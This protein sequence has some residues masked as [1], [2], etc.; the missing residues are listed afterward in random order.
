[1]NSKITLWRTLL[2]AILLFGYSNYSK[3][4]YD[5]IRS[6]AKSSLDTI[7][8][9]ATSIP[10]V[11]ENG[12]WTAKNSV[13]DKVIS[14]FVTTI[15]T[16]VT[17][18]QSPA[19]FYWTVT[20]INSNIIS[21]DSFI[22][23]D[24]SVELETITDEDLCALDTATLDLSGLYLGVPTY[25]MW[26]ASNLISDPFQAD[27]G[28]FVT[29]YDT[30][31]ASVTIGNMYCSDTK[32]FK[33]TT[34]KNQYFSSAIVPAT[35]YG[36]YD[37]HILTSAL[38]SMLYYYVWSTGD[39]IV[40]LH[41][42]DPGAYTLT[43]YAKNPQSSCTYVYDFYVYMNDSTAANNCK[44]YP[45][46]NG[47]K[48]YNNERIINFENLTSGTDTLGK[49]SYWEFG[50]GEFSYETSPSHTYS[51]NGV[52]MVT[53]T[54]FSNTCSQNFVNYI[55]VGTINCFADFTIKKSLTNPK[56]FTITNQSQGNIDSYSWDFGDGTLSFEANPGTHTF[57]ENGVYYMTLTVRNDSTNCVYTGYEYVHVGDSVCFADFELF[58]DQQTDSVTFSNNSLNFGSGT[59]WY[60]TMGDTYYGYSES[61]IHKYAEDGVY[62]VCLSGYDYS[63]D[64][65]HESCKDVTVGKNVI[66]A[67]YTYLVDATTKSITLNES[68][69]GTAN[70]LFW[71]FGDGEYSEAPNVT[72]TYTKNGVYEV[73]LF[74]YNSYG[75]YDEICQEIAV[76]ESC[77]SKFAPVILDATAKEVKCTDES[78]DAAHW[79]W[80]FGDGSIDTTQNPKYKYWLP[81]EYLV[82]LS[83]ANK[84]F[85][86]FDY[87]S[88][89]VAVGA[90]DA[91]NAK[92]EYKVKADSNKVTF[93]NKSTGSVAYYYWDFGNGDFS[94]EKEPIYIYDSPGGYWVTLV[95]S[96]ASGLAFDVK[97]D[98]VQVGK[99]PCSAKFETFINEKTK[100]VSFTNQAKGNSDFSYWEFG[101][102]G[103]SF[104]SEPAHKYPYD[105][106]F[107][108]A[109]VTYHTAT[110]CMDYY[111]TD[112]QIGKI[113]GLSSNFK[114]QVKAEEMKVIFNSEV[115]GRPKYYVWNFDDNTDLS[116]EK[117]PTHTYTK[118]GYYDVCL[119]ISDSLGTYYD[120]ECKEVQVLPT[121]KKADFVQA[122]FVY[123]TDSINKKVTFTDKSVGDG[124]KYLWVFG[125]GT[126]SSDKNP[127]KTY[128]KADYYFVTLTVTKSSNSA[129]D[130]YASYINVSMGNNGIKCGF[131]SAVLPETNTKGKGYPVDMVGATFGS[132]SK[133]IWDFGDGVIDSISATT[134]PTH[135]YAKPGK[136]NVC[137]TVKD[138]KTSTKTCNEITIAAT[139]IADVNASTGMGIT[140]Y[141]NPLQN[142][143]EI[144]YTVSQNGMVNIELYNMMGQ[145]VSTLL[146]ENRSAGTHTMSWNA[147]N[148][149]SGVYFLQLNTSKGKLTQKVVKE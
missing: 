58:V 13:T 15:S 91:V 20:D 125:D 120:M 136:Y 94:M 33:I 119:Y 114:F 122:K 92:F 108:A 44:L 39:T 124:D 115:K 79:F 27:S 23:V 123:K 139:G 37:G 104:D 97:Y 18:G 113:A 84:D 56:L 142:K 51:E 8:F 93:Q 16:G 31:Y 57:T 11:G 69:K 134:T 5:T 3:A 73:C 112:L 22:V 75:D 72:H 38:D 36:A 24:A 45:F 90:A 126:T 21:K 110:G 111:E 62:K 2:F 148:L 106:Y 131:G 83:I 12:M 61:I 47:Y 71:T 86:C 7:W 137:L 116:T 63:M 25:W 59:D 118:P 88:E 85:S 17:V 50:D 129:T 117:N 42:L 127:V 80:D 78:K 133:Y 29:P 107:T 82:S 41:Y 141:P 128:T 46:F 48:D 135:V 34:T 53:L 144:S 95:V 19:V 74:A 35:G 65:F 145:K 40:D 70:Y 81:G 96:D 149:K 130:S 77:K 66:N 9:S 132:G 10:T 52:Y 60:W 147:E 105:G 89:W 100:T 146:S 32:S 109:L 26:N 64:C 55:E 102:G 1:M 67:E 14:L 49:I 138:A 54:E 98:F 6:C 140:A 43:T 103:Y 121:N 68:I 87:S 99:I 76:G 101:D 143:A 28:T 4:S 30:S